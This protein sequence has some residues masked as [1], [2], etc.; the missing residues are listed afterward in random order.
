VVSILLFGPYVLL[1]KLTDRYHALRIVV[2]VFQHHLTQG[3]NL[4]S[5]SDAKAANT[6][7]LTAPH[8]NLATIILPNP[9]LLSAEKAALLLQPPQQS[10]QLPHHLAV[11]RPVPF[12]LAYYDGKVEDE[13][14][15]AVFPFA[16]A[17]RVANDA[18]VVDAKGEEAVAEL[19]GRDEELRD[20]CEGEERRGQRG[21]TGGRCYRAGGNLVEDAV[22]W[23]LG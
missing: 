12:I 2:D 3:V 20:R 14:I 5:T 22:S 7:I 13:L 10:A 8:M 17:D 18:I 19:L 21:G 6:I 9:L 16:N 4:T 1:R 15:P 11:A 23:Y